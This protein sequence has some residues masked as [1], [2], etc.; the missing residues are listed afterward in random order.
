MVWQSAA[1]RWVV[2]AAIVF[3]GV[4]PGPAAASAPDRDL[5]GRCETERWDTVDQ[6]LQRRA[7]NLKQAQQLLRL[8]QDAQRPD[9]VERAQ[10][11]LTR[12]QGEWEYINALASALQTPGYKSSLARQQLE[13]ETRYDATRQ[14]LKRKTEQWRRL[15]SLTGQR[16]QTELNQMHTLADEE[17]RGRLTLAARSGRGALSA[18][19]HH[20]S[21][22]LKT[23]KSVPSSAIDW[24]DDIKRYE[25][26]VALN[27]A[28]KAG[29][30]GAAA[31]K[32]D[33]WKLGTMAGETMLKQIIP[34]VLT[35]TYK[36]PI[37]VAASTALA[38]LTAFTFVLKVGLDV[39][40]IGLA[41]EQF[42]AAERRLNAARSAE[43]TWQV[44][45]A[46]LGS[47][48]RHLEAQR[49]VLVEAS[50]RQALLEAQI[51]V[52]RGEISK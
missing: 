5:C 2:F 25:S 15:Q 39:A 27:N 22:A 18:A 21:L 49:D 29:E 8:A 51:G 42:D 47:T 32:R 24:S 45:I 31:G 19:A 23:L 12:A 4:L 17:A 36:V 6:Q 43:L 40:D 35:T 50:R 28:V 7:A 33:Y 11:A 41:H 30:A 14:E 13:I 16:R 37:S 48:L 9:V 46:V 26:V 10:Q 20:A 1:R 44:E 38:Q 3:S 34:A 52:I